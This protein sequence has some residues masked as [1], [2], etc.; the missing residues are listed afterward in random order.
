MLGNT[1][2]ELYFSFDELLAIAFDHDLLGLI[3]FFCRRRKVIIYG[4]SVKAVDVD[5]VNIRRE[6][7]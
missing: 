1:G 3:D 7:K 5:D 6:E 4:L 2:L